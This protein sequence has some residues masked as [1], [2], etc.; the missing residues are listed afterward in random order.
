MTNWTSAPPNA[1]EANKRGWARMLKPLGAVIAGLGATFAFVWTVSQPFRYVVC[2]VPVAMTI[3][4]YEYRQVSKGD[5]EQ[6]VDR[7]LTEFKGQAISQPG[8]WQGFVVDVSDVDVQAFLKGWNSVVYAHQTS[9]GI[10]AAP[11]R[12]NTFG[13]SAYRYA[14]DGDMSRSDYYEIT[15]V[16]VFEA[17]IVVNLVNTINGVRISSISSDPDEYIAR[18]TGVTRQMNTNGAHY[19]KMDRESHGYEIA[20]QD[21]ATLYCQVRDD[22]HHWWGRSYLGWV[23][24]DLYLEEGEPD[25]DL[26]ECT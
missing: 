7:F 24:I 13:F 5:A 25:P 4:P 10:E 3:C 15:S 1:E 26:R 22:T 8:T 21:S 11:G 17:R 9:G 14:L 6:L 18:L 20:E 12:S 2:Q 16:D 19:D 23:P